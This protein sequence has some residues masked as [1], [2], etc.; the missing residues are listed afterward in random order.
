M[1]LLAAIVTGNSNAAMTWGLSVA[2][3][4]GSSC[5]ILSSSA[6]SSVYAA[7]FVAP[8]HATV[9]LDE[10]RAADPAKSA[11]VN[12]A[13]VP[14]AVVAPPI[15]IN[16]SG[17]EYSWGH[18][19][20]TKDLAFLKSNNISLIRLPIAWE[21]AQPALLGPLDQKYLSALATF[22]NAAGAQGMN[23]IVDVHDYG[24]YNVNWAKDLAANGIATPGTGTDEEIIGSG[25]VPIS[26][27]ADFW[28]KLARAL[29]GTPGL[30]YYDIMNEPYNMGSTNVWPS[31]AQAAVD[32][33]RSVDSKTSILVEGTQW[34]SADRWP[35]DNGSLH[36]IDSANKLFYEAHL[37]FD[38]KE[39][40]TYSERYTQQGAYPNI[41]VDKLQPFLTWLKQNGAKGFL[42]EFGIPGN[43]PEWLPVLDNFLAAVQGAGLSGT[44][45]NYVFHSPSD[46][47]WWPVNDPM[48]IRLD[49]GQANPQMDILSKRN[50]VPPQ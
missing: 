8:S 28:T 6:K 43:D 22:I 13:I 33:V 2:G 47:S 19:A 9:R 12:V 5:G 35:S 7:P 14:R 39:S 34:A 48:S 25:V 18:F 11:S 3:C 4:T 1:Q 16:V 36:I 10:T 26:A 17:A 40:G 20:G 23:V 29:K 50:T 31:A 45:W 27:F 37:Y 46:P 41:G 21:R 15:G 38:G 24:R 32:A 30:S 44:Y 42:G 49:N